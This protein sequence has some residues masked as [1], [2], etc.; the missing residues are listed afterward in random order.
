MDIEDF[1]LGEIFKNKPFFEDE[2]MKVV[3]ILHEFS[4]GGSNYAKRVQLVVWKKKNT[5][6]AD[7]DIRTFLKKENQYQKGIT[8]SLREAKELSEILSHFFSHT[9]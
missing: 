5:D 4:N 2:Y 1:L 3:K 7:L 8:L 6:V 9:K